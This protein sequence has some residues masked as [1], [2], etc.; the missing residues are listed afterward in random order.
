MGEM[1]ENAKKYIHHDMKD[2]TS[3]RAKMFYSLREI[4]FGLEDG[5]VSTLGAVTG[6]AAGTNN[7]YVVILAGFVVVFVESLSMAAGTFLSSKSEH[8]VQQRILAE[9]SEEIEEQPEQEKKELG[10]YYAQRGY[11]QQEIEILVRRVTSDKKLWLEEMAHKE[12]GIIEEPKRGYVMDAVFMGVSY[13][14]GGFIP[15]TAYFFLRDISLGIM[16]SIGCSLVALFVLG[17]VKGK[18]VHINKIRSGL[19]MMFISLTAAGLGFLVGR[20]VS[21]TFEI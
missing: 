20:I 4:V 7:Y 10:G 18:L 9:V 2:G 16:V 12:L 13:I 6:I 17:Y 5:V 8:E 3:F 1:Q 15:L 14:V 21:S 11:T 19:E